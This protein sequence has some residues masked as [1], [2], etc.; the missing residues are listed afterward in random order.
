MTTLTR[1]DWRG[2]KAGWTPRER[3]T[4][5]RDGDASGTYRIQVDFDP[6]AADRTIHIKIG[7]ATAKLDAARNKGRVIFDRVMLAKGDAKIEAWLQGEKRVGVEIR[8]S[9][10]NG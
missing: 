4:L 9:G 5:G 3:R 6:A 2:P 1:Q 10:E 7:D 8:R